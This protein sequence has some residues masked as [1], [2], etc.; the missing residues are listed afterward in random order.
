MALEG[1]QT[2]DAR[3]RLDVTAAGKLI[4]A[5]PVTPLL[6][7][8]LA[9]AVLGYFF[10]SFDN[11]IVAYVLPVLTR[12]WE[13]S[14]AVVGSIGSAGLWGSVLGAYAWG[15]I[16]DRWGRVIAFATAA[17][18][19]GL[20]TGLTALA[21]DSSS[22]LVLRLLAGIGLGGMV[23][24]DGVFVAEYAPTR[25]RS[26]FVGLVPL[27]FPLGQFA[28]TLVSLFVIPAWGWQSVFI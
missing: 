4:D 23:A 7:Y 24:I 27:A 17:L 26:L 22:L 6:K 25:L 21:Q 16:S 10:D 20:L 12:Q 15:F 28:A 9:A 2:G 1:V 8:T 18:C 19:F 11:Q 3:L 14:P 13:L 5:L